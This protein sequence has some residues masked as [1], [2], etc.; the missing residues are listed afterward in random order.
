[1]TATVIPTKVQVEIPLMEE[2]APAS[3]VNC[4]LVLEKLESPAPQRHFARRWETAILFQT[5]FFA[6]ATSY[7][8]SQQQHQMRHDNFSNNPAPTTTPILRSPRQLYELQEILKSYNWEWVLVRIDA[9]TNLPLESLGTDLPDPEF[10]IRVKG[11]EA[12]SNNTTTTPQSSLL[13]IDIPFSGDLTSFSWPI[14]WN[15]PTNMTN[16][17]GLGIVAYLKGTAASIDFIVTEK[18]QVD[19]GY[20]VFH[21]TIDHL[22]A[23]DLDNWTRYSL[24]QRQDEEEVNQY[25]YAVQNGMTISVEL[26]MKRMTHPL[27]SELDHANMGLVEYLIHLENGELASLAHKV[28]IPQKHLG[29]NSNI[30]KNDNKAVVYFAGRSDSFAH[31]HV[32]KMYEQ[33]GY[34][35]YTLDV[36][37]SGRARRFLKNPHLGNDVVDFEEF[38][39][40]VELALKYINR[41]K[42]YT[43][44]V[45]HCHSNGALVLFSY[46]LHHQQ[47]LTLPD[48]DGYILNS[49]FLAW[50]N[51]GGTLNEWLLKN[52]AMINYYLYPQELWGHAG[53][54][55]DWWTKVW[56][57]Y[58]WNLAWK[59]VITNSLT[60]HYAEAVS[61]I[62][63]Q[64]HD[65]EGFLLRDKPTLV[66]SSQS[67]DV[68]Q[69]CEILQLAAK[70]HPNPTLVEFD[71][72]S[73]DVT[74]SMTHDLNDRAIKVI[75]DWLEDL[76]T[77]R[78]V[79]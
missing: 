43:Q 27:Y 12:N 21:Q 71:F 72:H 61:S 29:K 9:V 2:M 63:Q 64:V 78:S 65:F 55:N 6:L 73:H 41:Q 77:Y 19:Q 37:R 31:P 49:P 58:R 40:D 44:L 34:D 45:A 56:I 60:S 7:Y 79:D 46:L 66:M 5:L 69:H 1:M 25:H 74:K 52:A 50:G 38:V 32:L 62:H 76:I 39:E 13:P 70:L 68:L 24:H 57:L 15:V 35:F 75:S 28:Q 67:D 33:A 11:T 14:L 48:F 18:N 17:K 8:L 59:P 16:V 10:R 23:T 30:K 3:P 26:V 20:V 47:H 22:P 4:R 51:V 54:L 42:N 36:R 53:S